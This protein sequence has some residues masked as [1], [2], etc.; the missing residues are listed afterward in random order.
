M[1]LDLDSALRSTFTSN[2]SDP[3]SPLM[4]SDTL[5]EPNTHQEIF[6]KP[7]TSPSVFY[8]NPIYIILS[9]IELKILQG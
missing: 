7:H 5:P 2:E 9:R 6:S 1:C 4:S 8:I 3:L